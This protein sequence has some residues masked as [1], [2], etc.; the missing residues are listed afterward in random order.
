METTYFQDLKIEY[1]LQLSSQHCWFNYF[2]FSL[3]SCRHVG[4]VCQ[5]ASPNA[6]YV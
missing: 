3:S 5:M 4:T 6:S 2:I 1:R